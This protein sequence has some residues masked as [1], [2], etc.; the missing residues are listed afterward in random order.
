M[1]RVSAADTDRISVQSAWNARSAPRTR[2]SRTTNPAALEAV[3]AKATIGVGPPSYTSGAHM[4]KGTAAILNPTAAST[5]ISPNNSSG[6][7]ARP[8][9]AFV[10]PESIVVPVAA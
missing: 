10:S 6:S 4:W 9:S 7:V 8:A 5:R 2:R 1:T 3:E